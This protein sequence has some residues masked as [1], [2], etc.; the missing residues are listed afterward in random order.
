MTKNTTPEFIYDQ[1]SS[2]SNI[3]NSISESTFHLRNIEL[4]DYYKE[5]YKTNI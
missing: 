2:K 3:S 4:I 1:V 5:N